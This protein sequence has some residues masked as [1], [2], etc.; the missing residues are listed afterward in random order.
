MFK[1]RLDVLPKDQHCLWGQLCE[2]RRFLAKHDYY[3]AGGTAL[4]LQIGHRQSLDFDFFSRKNA[5]GRLTQ[6]WIQKLAGCVIRDLDTNTVHAE[7]RGAKISFIGAYRYRTV[8]PLVDA[9]GIKIA[10][11]VDIGLMK[12][13]AVTHRATLRDYI[14]LAA[15]LKRLVPLKNLMVASRKKYGKKFNVLMCLRALVTF[16][17]IDQEMPNLI[18]R[19]LATSWQNVLREAVKREMRRQI[20]GSERDPASFVDD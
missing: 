6:D 15:I 17:D 4:A 18:D 14:D 2:R 12:L 7:V 19:T 10:S 1:P 13:L 3:L 8:E 9:N 20:D 16:G 11:V 5:L